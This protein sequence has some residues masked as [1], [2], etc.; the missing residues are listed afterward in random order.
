MILLENNI[1]GNG[2]S[3]RILYRIRRL[4]QRDII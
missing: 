4:Q 1:L 3:L 2:K